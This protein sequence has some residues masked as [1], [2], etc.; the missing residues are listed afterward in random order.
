[1][2]L[3]LRLSGYLKI[4]MQSFIKGTTIKHSFRRV[5]ICVE[6]YVVVIELNK[7][8]RKAKFITAYL[9]DGINGKGKKAIDLIQ[10]GKKW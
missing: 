2:D 6:N 4:K 8:R 10:S 9:A 7:K 3:M 1:M 5:A